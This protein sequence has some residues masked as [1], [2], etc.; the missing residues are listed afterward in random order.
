MRDRLAT[1]WV[2]VF[3]SS[4]LASCGG[5]GEEPAISDGGVDSPRPAVDARPANDARSDELLDRLRAVIGITVEELAP[6]AAGARLFALGLEQP[7]RH[8]DPGGRRFVQRLLLYHVGE[9]APVVLFA[10]GYMLGGAGAVRDEVAVVA[11]ANQLTV[12]HRFFGTSVAEDAD[13]SALSIAEAAADWH[14][15]VTALRPIYPGRWLGAGGSK[16]GA[17]ALFHRRFYPD[18]VAGTVAFVTPISRGAPDGRYPPYVATRGG[19]GLDGCRAGIARAQREALLR[20]EAMQQRMLGSTLRFDV[21]GLDKA[22][23][24]AVLELPFLFWMNGRA[25]LC[26]LLPPE[27]PTDAEVFDFVEGTAITA[28]YSDEFIAAY[29][30]F[31]HQTANQLGWPAHDESGLADL[32]TQPGGDRAGAYVPHL[33]TGWDG[34]AAMQDVAAWIQDEGSQLLFIYGEDDPWTAGAVELGG[35]HSRDSWKLVAPGENHHVR[36]SGLGAGDRAIAEDAIRRW[37][38]R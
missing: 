26:A 23:E 37:A 16:G 35:A 10:T 11:G 6:P 24:D 38:G 31:Y 30:G 15:V 8:A 1:M 18:D 29:A 20:R 25:S 19:A 2:T 13:W 5:A 36:L 28:Q 3:F 4:V 27:S 17:A 14:R 22:L 34:G 9:D 21:L 33:E 12:E 32:L 7:E